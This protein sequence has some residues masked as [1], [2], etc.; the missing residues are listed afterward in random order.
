MTF[1][2]ITKTISDY[3]WG[4][5]LIVLILLAGLVLTI[6]TKFVQVR[7]FKNS[8]KF[9][10]SDEVG[11]EGE[12]STFAALCVALSATIGTGNIVGVA[13][14]IATGGPGAL[15]WMLVAAFL[16]MA[17]KY[18][19][20][21]LAIKY[22]HF[23][24][25]GKPIGG[26]FYYIEKG[27][28]KK[29][30][31]LAK[32]FAAF[33]ALAGLLGIGTFAQVN[34]ISSA[35]KNLFDPNN[36]NI[37][38]KIGENS[39]SWAVVIGGAIITLA[40]AFVVIGGIKN[41]GVIDVIGSAIASLGSGSTFMVYTIIVWMSVILS[42]FI[43]NIPYTATML[44]IVP[45]ISCILAIVPVLFYN[46]NSKTLGKIAADLEERKAISDGETA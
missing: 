5:P 41:A 34:S 18:A 8:M 17:T 25:E 29:W 45:V 26:P 42:A 23:D 19:E 35:I 46:L 12:I 38:F 21:F 33:G 15:F 37:A 30:I 2:E 10:V 40:T 4:L 1:E 39:Y 6:C 43:D 36:E 3:I 11:G 28:G 20:G 27:M 32:A 7:H 14:A 31:W 9:M 16:G 13:T 44:S 24:S 22:R